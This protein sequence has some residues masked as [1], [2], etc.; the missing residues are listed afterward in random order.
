MGRAA[1]V[2]TCLIL[3]G[4]IFTGTATAAQNLQVG[5]FLPDRTRQ[6]ISDHQAKVG[7][8]QDIIMFYQ[9]WGSYG[10]DLDAER[11]QWII[12]NGSIPMI[13]WEPWTW[14]GPTTNQPDYSLGKII[15]GDH[16]AYIRRF[17]QEVK[18]FDK[19]IY[20]RPMH[21]MN[22]DW[23]PWAG[24]QNGNNPS[25]YVPAYR[26]IVNIFRQEGVSNV[27]WVWSPNNAGLPDWGT[28]SFSTYYP[29]DDYVD[30]AAIDGYNFGK[31]Q[32]WSSWASFSAIFDQAYR[33]ITSLTQ[34]PIIIAETSSAEAGGSKAAWISDAFSKIASDY[35]KIS[36]V[37]WFN[38]AGEADWRVE[39][40]PAALAAYK[41]ALGRI[42]S[43]PSPVP[44]PD[45]K[46][47][48]TGALIINDGAGWT[49]SRDVTL[50]L[51]GTDPGGN[52]TVMM[53][54]RNHAST[55]QSW[56]PFS[57][58]KAW[59]LSSG[60]GS[61]KVDLQLKDGAGNVSTVYSDAIVYDSKA[62]NIQV[63]SP[64]VSTRQS[65]TSQFTVRWG[66]PASPTDPHAS[67]TIRYH[68]EKAKTWK[69]LLANT[70]STSRLF[71]GKMGR[72]YY[73]KVI[74]R[75]EA[76]NRRSSAVK[77]TIVPYNDRS[78]IVMNRGFKALTPNT[79]PARFYK[80]TLRMSYKRGA[81]IVY[82]F[83]G[84]SA[85]LV[86]SKGP[87]RGKAK[88]YIDGR[89]TAT[90]DAYSPT[91]KT[92]QLVLRKRW[93]KTGTHFLKVVNLGTPGKARFDVDALAVGR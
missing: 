82:Q 21:E 90:I 12:D 85:G 38:E 27:R 44:P 34:K 72:T 91:L 64:D 8:R 74:A 3:I 29:G 16:D 80:N 89:Y 71:K 7:R 69:T 59:V 13:T 83:D 77:T 37:I 2:I 48:P 88:I 76:G 67:Y 20:L 43:T 47:P 41:A 39:S 50:G 79:P 68:T 1:I 10:G 56:Q 4:L 18:Q 36:A 81:E 22:G 75:D 45:D 55:W 93:K 17:A 51:A 49:R 86:A 84:R 15:D 58:P 23:Y 78:N 33:A 53:R 11:V 66:D 35:P 31:S 46:T 65:A 57:S 32:A 9:A 62:P 6:A 30:F 5:V 42:G 60:N 24:T 54:L 19:I 70:R 61:K 26:R 14:G 92:R 25:Q 87:N 52:G 63:S 73:I 28:S 40:S